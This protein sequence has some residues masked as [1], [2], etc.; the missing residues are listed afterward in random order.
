MFARLL[1]GYTYLVTE[2]EKGFFVCQKVKVVHTIGKKVA[3]LVAAS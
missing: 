2:E 1:N 3:L